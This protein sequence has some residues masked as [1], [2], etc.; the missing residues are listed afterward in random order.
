MATGFVVTGDHIKSVSAKCAEIQR[1]IQQR[2]GCPWNPDA[3]NSALQSIVEGR[4]PGALNEGLGSRLF[5]RTCTVQLDNKRR[6]DVTEFFQEGDQ[7]NKPRLFF[8][9]E[10]KEEF[11]DNGHNAVLDEHAS[12]SSLVGFRLCKELT[13]SQILACAGGE[14]VEVSLLH[15]AHLLMQQTPNEYGNLL[16]AGE[17]SNVFFMKNKDKVLRL[18]YCRGHIGEGNFLFRRDGNPIG[19]DIGCLP[20]DNPKH[21]RM[22]TRLFLPTD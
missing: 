16:R 2:K 10:F 13:G 1:L 19:W 8:D 17:W 4:F 14:D 20:I 3:I 18:V 7:T 9:K 21:W 22:G 11:L 6:V 15:L 5:E 12:I